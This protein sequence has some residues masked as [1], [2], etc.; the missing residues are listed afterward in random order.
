MDFESEDSTETVQ[1]RDEMNQIIDKFNGLYNSENK[2]QSDE[3]EYAYL[4][5]D[6]AAFRI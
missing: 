3:S 5:M 1:I 4:A 2:E 6:A